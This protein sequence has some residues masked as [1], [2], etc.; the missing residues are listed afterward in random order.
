MR[1]K[2][3]AIP[4][5]GRDWRGQ[6][7]EFLD[8]VHFAVPERVL[9]SLLVSP[10]T[11]DKSDLRRIAAPNILLPSGR[12]YGSAGQGRLD[13]IEQSRTRAG[14]SISAQKLPLVLQAPSREGQRVAVHY[15]TVHGCLQ[16]IEIAL[17]ERVAFIKA[18]A[19]RTLDSR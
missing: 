18:R 11:S 3:E 8:G 5:V 7:V 12:A 1:R 4:G 15:P 13:D 10:T 14:V 9:V 19:L 16:R 17:L 6:F 2:E